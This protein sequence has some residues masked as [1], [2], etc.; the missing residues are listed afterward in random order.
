[1]DV[2]CGQKFFIKHP[3]IVSFKGKSTDPYPD[4]QK[5]T[6]E[7]LVASSYLIPSYHK[8]TPSYSTFSRPALVPA[9]LPTWKRIFS[10][11]GAC[12]LQLRMKEPNFRSCLSPLSMPPSST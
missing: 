9:V 1:M 2:K 11:K 10:S 6:R 5:T 3:Y 12:R 4:P 8:R 7:E